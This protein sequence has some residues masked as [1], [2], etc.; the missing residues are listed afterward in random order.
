MKEKSTRLSPTF[1]FVFGMVCLLVHSEAFSYWNCAWP[2][3]TEI[4]VQDNSGLNLTNYQIK[5]EL[6]GSVLNSA[7]DWTINGFD[8]RFVNSD[9][10]SVMDYWIESWDQAN[11]SAT[12]WVRLPNL[13]AGELKTLYV[14][15][16]N[17][18]A[19]Q[20]DNIP[21]TFVDP[22][23]KF[24]TRPSTINPNS[25]SDAFA[26]FNLSNDNNAG[27]G[28]AFITNFTGIT[29]SNTFGAGSNFVAYSETYFNVAEG[30]EGNWGIRYGADFGGGGG[31]YVDGQTL[32]E[33]WFND[34]W[35]SNNWSSADVL[36]GSINLTHGYHKLEVIGTEGCCDGGITVQFQ[37]PGGPWTTYSTASIDIVSRSCPQVVP[38]VTFGAQATS[39]CPLPI[40]QYRVDETRWSSAGDVIDSMGGSHG[41]MLGDVTSEPDS[42]VC[43]GATVPNNDNHNAIEGIRTGIDVDAHIGNVGSIAFWVRTETPWSDSLSRTLFDASLDNTQGGSDKY[44][45][46]EKLG[47]G[48]LRFR[49]ED[50]NDGDYSMIENSIPTRTAGTWY[51]VTVTWDMPSNRY[52]IYVSD[53]E[54]ASAIINTN[55]QLSDLTWLLVGDNASSFYTIAPGRSAYATFDEITIYDRVITPSQIRGLMS[56]TRS[57]AAPVEFCKA[58]FPDGLNNLAG[59]QLQF[60]LQAALFN[61]PDTVLSASNI[62]KDGASTQL[63][64]GTADCTSGGASVIQGNP[65]SFQTT[66]VATDRTVSANSNVTLGA[67]FDELDNLT[68]RSNA[69]LTMATGASSIKVDRLRLQQGSTLNLEAGTYWINQIRVRNNVRINVLSTPVR[70]HI[71]RVT[72]WGSGT[73]INSPSAA[74]AGLAQNLLMYFYDDIAFG[75]STTLSAALYGAA[76]T[77]FGGSSFI[78]GLITS[79]DIVLGNNTR[80]EYSAQTYGGLSDVSWCQGSS[81]ALASINITAPASAI[82]CL[83][84]QFTV[85]M[86]DNN[87]DVLTNFS[88]D[89]QLATST[90]H[91]DW[92]IVSGDGA[93]TQSTADSGQ[94]TYSMVSTDNGV[95]NLSLKNTHPETT[96]VS[97]SAEGI[98]TT[99]SITFQSAGFV[100]SNISPQVANKVSA[101][102]QLSAVQTDGVTGACEAMLVNSN[103]VDMAIECENPANCGSAS[104]RITG[105]SA[106]QSVSANPQNNLSN[107]SAVD[108]DF[109]NATDYDASFNLHYSEAGQI[110]LHARYELKDALGNGTGN[111]IVGISNSFPVTPD[112]FCIQSND[113]NWTCPT[114]DSD[115]SVFKK[116]GEDFSLAITAMQY[117]QNADTDYCDNAQTYNFNGAVDIA[118]QK[119]APT[120]GTLGTIGVN[121]MTL[122]AGTQTVAN[123]YVSEV[124]VFRLTAGGNGYLTTTLPSNG[125]VSMGRFIPDQF[126]I[127]QSND[128]AFNSACNGFTYIGQQ[129]LNGSVWQGAIQYQTTP[130]DSRPNVLYQAKN[131]LGD[132]TQNYR[133]DFIKNPQLSLT[134]SSP[135]LGTDGMTPFSVVADFHATTASFDAG[136]TTLTQTLNASDHF[137]YVKSA[138]SEVTPFTN[139][140]RININDIQ[141]DDGVRL[142]NGPDAFN[143]SGGEIRFGRLV[144]NDVYGPETEGLTMSLQSEYLANTGLYQLTAD[145]NGCTAYPV[146]QFV[147]SSYT[148]DLVSGDT[149]LSGSGTLTNGLGSWDLTAPDDEHVG[150]VDVTLNTAN[151][152][153]LRYDWDQNGAHDNDPQA[154]A[155]F[156]VY[157]GNDRVIYWK[158]INY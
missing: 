137:Y 139:N 115:C 58:T 52:K 22:G 7:Y 134:A 149:T 74:T 116:A 108:L 131:T 67:G 90:A 1:I 143:P 150:S 114:D 62:L 158:E 119:I 35:W 88:G 10:L 38:T 34:L 130:T 70:L 47:D 45:F 136:A 43:R 51:H 95:V 12:V 17:I 53:Q 9:D 100:F 36:Q 153:W 155:T 81:I 87:G 145:D 103:D 124:G 18:Y 92:A 106:A 78:S 29:N 68:V 157:R 94:A 46:L 80:V 41:S 8:L 111:F 56:K 15:Y 69:T 127:T 23:I 2:Y 6:S 72:N 5:I 77:S 121:S 25:K 16:G 113:A 4:Q 144:I 104:A 75:A 128:G 93:L 147:T 57:C 19:D 59:G 109:G 30:E 32:E 152:F 73:I 97:V 151:I 129:A 21:F 13:N 63:T 71:N 24:H 28:C 123:Q 61:N 118:L 82:N 102:Y 49:F 37:K 26:A 64:C 79:N 31:L 107:Y 154:T 148:G 39:S 146:G 3:R 33:D 99:Q 126:E 14:Y 27:Y 117:Q 125:S 48:R 20:L 98:T 101:A 84:T 91:G 66:N 60:G 40:A 156:G 76:D 85:E 141:D 86:R 138:Q 89:L 140:I 11:E 122:S 54:V 42:Q 105:A 50:S 110:R 65:G 132:V 133:G 96:T 135:Q 44:F 55:Q 112:G 120:D 83:P 142:G